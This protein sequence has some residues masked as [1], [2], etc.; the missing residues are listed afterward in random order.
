[1][2]I[3]QH[4]H[5]VDD[6]TNPLGIMYWRD[7]MLLHDWVSSSV[8]S[9]DAVSET[10]TLS[11]DDLERLLRFATTES[12]T[13]DENTGHHQDAAS[14]QAGIL[15]IMPRIK[16]DENVIYSERRNAV[17]TSDD[18]RTQRIL[19]KPLDPYVSD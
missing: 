11:F 13:R 4:I 9:Y 19:V 18:P 6:P 5:R 15:A 7:N 17:S 8:R 1:M 3:D 2:G 16:K 14:I 10:A 12:Q